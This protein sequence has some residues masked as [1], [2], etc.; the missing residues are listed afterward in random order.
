MRSCASLLVLAAC[1][2]DPVLHVTVTHPTGVTIAS[3]TVTV[4]ESKM[5][6]C[7]DIA[8]GDIDD[9][10]L[11]AAQVASETIGAQGTTGA[12]TGLSRT[13]TKLV[14]ARGYDANGGLL[15]AGCAEQGV[16]SGDVELAITTELAAVV[17]YA[18]ADPMG[19]DLYGIATTV[20]DPSGKEIDNR[21]VWWRVYGPAGTSA[22][23]TPT[24]LTGISDG[25]WE[26]TQPTCTS[27]GLATI[28]PVPPNQIG[29]FA[30]EL[31]VAW[32]V[33]PPQYFS[34]FTRIDPSLTSLSPPANS[35]H[36]CTRHVSGGTPKLTCLDSGPVAYDFTVGEANGTATLSPKASTPSQAVDPNT[37]GLFGIDN[38]SGG[39]DV[40]AATTHCAIASAVGIAPKDGTAY[41]PLQMA[42]DILLVPACGS[43]PARLLFHIPMAVND[44]V[45]AVDPLGG[46]MSDL[47]YSPKGS[48]SFN[49]AGCVSELDPITGQTTPRQVI[50]IDNT[51]AGVTAG[52][53]ALYDCTTTCSQIVLPLPGAGV[54]FTG[55][56]EQRMI[57]ATIDASGVVLSQLVLLRDTTGAADRL[58]E[59][60]RQPA[61][62]VPL[63]IAV[64][65]FDADGVDDLVWDVAVRRG[66]TTAFEVAYARMVNGEPLAALSG[67]FGAQI[68]TIEVGDVTGDNR[69]DIVVTGAAAAIVHGVGVIPTRVAPQGG[70]LIGDTNPCAP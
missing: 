39:H 62:S 3:T 40:Y 54:G 61:A 66:A 50:V 41:C 27:K 17:S 11:Q 18:L 44:V 64:G 68:A 42:D 67:A 14:V 13:D 19:T 65:N 7:Q 53:R 33:D 52:T 2:S 45:R 55:G 12:L 6:A 23:P 31:R 20:T 4:Y 59:R 32:A 34:S 57:A 48:V 30:V 25:I 16:V 37:L 36:F 46:N 38:A 49:A 58:V 1:S 70:N 56:S 9:V 43:S 51:V 5:F 47:S 22:Q 24:D 29:G 26:P 21:Q 8:Y 10:S 69:D 15:A 60:T 35:N 28:H 63:S